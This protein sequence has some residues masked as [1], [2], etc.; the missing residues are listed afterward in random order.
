MEELRQMNSKTRIQKH[1]HTE[2][3]H[4]IWHR[5]TTNH[6]SE[7]TDLLWRRTSCSMPNASKREYSMKRKR[8]ESEQLSEGGFGAGSSS[9]PHINPDELCPPLGS[10][11]A[12]DCEPSTKRRKKC[13]PSSSSAL[14][15]MMDRKLVSILISQSIATWYGRKTTQ[16]VLFSSISKS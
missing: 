14:L 13:V 7:A 12:E 16:S 8:A 6:K 10:L 2:G 5:G 3:T 1:K 9:A 4:K 11:F 15:W